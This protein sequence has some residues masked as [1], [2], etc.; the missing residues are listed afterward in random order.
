MVGFPDD[1]YLSLTNY[2][3]YAEHLYKMI[4]TLYNFWNFVSKALPTVSVSFSAATALIL[5]SKE[6]S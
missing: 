6:Y 3:K 5:S 1:I 2:T 4:P